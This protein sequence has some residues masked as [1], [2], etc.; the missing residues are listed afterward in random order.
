V[1]FVSLE[2]GERLL[3]DRFLDDI[4]RERS[5]VSADGFLQDAHVLAQELPKRIRMEAYRFKL[6]ESAIALCI[7][8]NPI[9]PNLP[10]TPSQISG[11]RNTLDR[12]EILHVLYCSLIGEPFAWSSI[13]NGNLI[14]DVIP[15]CENAD[16]PMSS[17]STHLFDFH[18]ED[19]FH[20]WAGDYLGLLCL[21]N[22]SRTPTLIACIDD[23]TLGGESMKLL[24]ERRF[25]IGANVAHDVPVSARR[26]PVLFGS[27]SRPYLRINTNVDPQLADDQQALNAYRELVDQ[28]REHSKEVVL[29]PGDCFVLDNLR[30]AHGRSSYKPEYAGADR[31][32]KRIYIT[33]DLRKSRRLRVTSESRLINSQ[34][35]VSYE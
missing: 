5:T 31:W 4:L 3:V 28:L 27:R 14:N 7:K 13:Q 26:I 6:A 18:T 15:I 12:Q 23:I 32:L 21:R 29:E 34:L 8:N 33:S 9:S 11:R 10:P 24:F 25:V 16:K 17:G 30:A 22:P 2:A 19:A 1:A 20:P 35:Q